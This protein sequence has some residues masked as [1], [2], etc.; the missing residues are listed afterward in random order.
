MRQRRILQQKRDQR[1]NN[2]LKGNV[3]DDVIPYGIW[4]SEPH[5][6]RR[7]VD[8]GT[9]T[10]ST[11]GITSGGFSFQLD[12]VPNFAEFQ[13]LFDLYKIEY[14]EVHMLP[15]FTNVLPSTATTFTTVRVAT[16]I[17]YNSSG[18]FATFDD[19]RDFESAQVT[20]VCAVSARKIHPMYLTGVEEDGSTI[21]VG[22]ASRGWL[23]TTR[24][25][26]PHYGFRYA[27][28]QAPATYSLSVKCEAVYYLTFKSV[29]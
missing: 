6:F 9:I 12:E 21:V 13:S 5:H 18:A 16:V 15:S 26:I 25:D 8:L 17:D 20:D 22:G 10:L 14:A 24:A 23:N 7:H 1:R 2:Q 29:K 4:R 3:T 28:E 27:F 19:A 11:A